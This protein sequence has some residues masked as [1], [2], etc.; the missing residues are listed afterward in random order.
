MPK[1]HKKS[2]GKAPKRP[3]P[4]PET[5]NSSDEDEEMAQLKALIARVDALEREQKLREAGLGDGG[6]TSGVAVPRR[7]NR[8]GRGEKLKQL[9]SSR[10]SSLEMTTGQQPQRDA[11]DAAEVDGSGAE[12]VPVAPHGGHAQGSWPP[13][14]LGEPAQALTGPDTAAHWAGVWDSRQDTTSTGFFQQPPAWGYGLAP[15]PGNQWFLQQAANLQPLIGQAGPQQE[16]SNRVATA[17][18][19][20]G[21]SPVSGHP[22]NLP[23]LGYQAAGIPQPGQYHLDNTLCISPYEAM[24]FRAASLV[25]F[26]GAFRP[27]EVILASA[28]DMTGRALALQD[29][30]F[31]GGRQTTAASAASVIAGGVSKLELMKVVEL[32]KTYQDQAKN[33]QEQISAQLTQQMQ[34]VKK[35]T[36]AIPEVRDSLSAVMTMMERK[37]TD[38]EDQ[39]NNQATAMLATYSVTDTRPSQLETNARAGNIRVMGLQNSEMKSCR[40]A[41]AVA[42]MEKFLH[43]LLNLP[44][45]LQLF[46]ER[47]YRIP[48]RMNKSSATPLSTTIWIV[49]FLRPTTCN[50]V[51]DAACKQACSVSVA[52]QP[53]IQLQPLSPLGKP[54]MSSWL[55]PQGSAPSSMPIAL[56]SHGARPGSCKTLSLEQDPDTSFEC[57]VVCKDEDAFC[58]SEENLAA[59]KDLLQQLESRRARNEAVCEELR[60]RIQTLWDRLQVPVKER[61]AFAPFMAGS[62]ASTRTALQLE[63]DCLEELK[64]QNLQHMVEAARAEL[65]DYWDYFYSP[66]QRQSFHPYYEEVFT[67]ELLQQHNDEV[68]QIKRYFEAHQEL[69]EAVHKWEKNWHQFQELERKAT[70]PSHF[71][72]RGGNLLKEE[73]L[74]AKVQKTLQ[75]VEEDLKS[76]VALWEEK[77]AQE[78]RVNGQP[79][80]EYVAEQWHLYH[81]EKEKEK[82]ERQL[83]NTFRSVLGG[84]VF[85]SPASHPPHSGGKPARTP[86]YAVPKPPRRGHLE[87]NKENLT[88]LNGTPLSAHT[89][90]GFHI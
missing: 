59:L 11:P 26:F 24:M 75:K 41:E 70:D 48:Q 52:L 43:S 39:I 82:Q 38:T 27:S 15:F 73:K 69:F 4:V 9:L 7:S 81:L 61:E 21:I 89:F 74:R 37:I 51:L 22:Y 83:K 85:H 42:L 8:K 33:N 77:H 18:P 67:E 6:G 45:D 76:Q 58:L 5:V 47:A 63:T 86:S 10:L 79:F 28:K 84:S 66:E 71:T 12:E 46:T 19:F 62:R 65:A 13:T 1:R 40:A 68:A 16:M 35:V 30:V 23:Y 34:E 14:S 3:N 20:T 2:G 25:M 57:D 60:S 80:V 44:E 53:I 56:R 72:N 36:R 55:H 50:L 49:Q 88:Q 32:M 78:F 29:V 64:L 31:M 87:H 90:K 17:L 54:L